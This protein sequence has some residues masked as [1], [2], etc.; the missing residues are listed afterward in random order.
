MG[1]CNAAVMQLETGAKLRK[2]T[3]NEFISATLYKQIIGSL[4]YLCNTKPVICQSVRL[5]SRFME[6]PQ[7][8][9]LTA[10][11]RVL[12]NIKSTIDHSVLMSRKTKTNTDAK[13][14]GYTDSDF[15]GDQDEKKSIAGYIF[16]IEGTPISQSSRKQSIVVLSSCEVEYVVAH[17]QHAKQ[18]G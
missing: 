5:L 12:R 15:S 3:N 6:K 14:Y 10:V 7:E 2:K 9:H 18:H 11:K 4:R 16:M 1:N 13:V 8:C 17:I